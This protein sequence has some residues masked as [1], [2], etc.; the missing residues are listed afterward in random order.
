MDT[1]DEFVKRVVKALNKSGLEYAITGALA[2]SYYGRPRT[3]MDMD[4]LIKVNIQDIPSLTETL[5]KAGLEADVRSIESAWS[6]RYRIAT[7]NDKKSPHTLDVILRS[8]EIDRRRGLILDIP[9]FYEAPGS[10]ILAKLRMMKATTQPERFIV[11]KEDVKAILKHT[12]IETWSLEEKAKE[13]G[14]YPLLK[15]LET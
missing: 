14:T 7:V 8:D 10:L 5:V 6:S 12:R 1:F 11:D 13:Q 15:Q 4:V 3:T 2:V 9:C